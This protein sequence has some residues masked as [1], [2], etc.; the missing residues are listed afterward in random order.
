MD[1]TLNVLPQKRTTIYERYLIFCGLHHHVAAVRAQPLHALLRSF[2][3]NMFH[4]LSYVLLHLKIR[5]VSNL[6]IVN[7]GSSII[8]QTEKVWV[9]HNYTH[10]S[11]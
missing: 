11:E 9:R 2:Q 6:Q 7:S 3:K 8:E 1:K 4:N 5:R 10:T